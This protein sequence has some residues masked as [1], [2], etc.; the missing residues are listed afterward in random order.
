MPRPARAKKMNLHLWKRGARRCHY[1]G[2]NLTRATIRADHVVPLSRG[3]YDKLSNCVASCEPCNQ[4]K[5]NMMPD[6]FAGVRRI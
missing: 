1:C 6:E 2:C 3:G 4:A 5:G